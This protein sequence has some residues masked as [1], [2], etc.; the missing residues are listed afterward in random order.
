MIH[1]PRVF[2]L[3]HR[4]PVARLCPQICHMASPVIVIDAGTGFTKMGYAGN[5][6]P[7]YIIPTIYAE[8]SSVQKGSKK[9]LDDLDFLIGSEALA[10]YQTYKVLGVCVGFGGGWSTVHILCKIAGL[11]ITFGDFFPEVF[12]HCLVGRAE[13]GPVA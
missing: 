1:Y 2:C 4:Q 5:Y 10:N 13:G 9:G 3:Y 8:N 6:E 7:S 11:D 12:W